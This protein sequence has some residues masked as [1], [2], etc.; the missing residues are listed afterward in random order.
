MPKDWT[1]WDILKKELINLGIKDQLVLQTLQDTPRP[2]FLPKN[3]RHF[4]V[5]NKPF[6]I[7]C[8]QTN[9]QPFMV[10]KMTELLKLNGCERVLEIGTGTGWQTT[11]LSRLAKTVFTIERFSELQKKAVKNFENFNCKNIHSKTGN[12][13]SGW[14]DQAPF[15][16]ILVTA[17]AVEIPNVL[18]DQLS[19]KGR[20]II[21]VGSLIQWLVCVD[22]CNDRIKIKKLF[23]VR[24][25]P[26][27]DVR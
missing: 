13:L 7:G 11:I 20:M 12:G 4:A 3:Y 21:P 27:I 9:S 5:E 22:K 23:P 6:P 2:I 18:L 1:G 16:R 24:F 14:K 8:S 26:L 25:V 17:S 19:E 15:D 10:A